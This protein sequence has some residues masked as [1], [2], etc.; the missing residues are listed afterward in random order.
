MGRIA[1]HS[2]A[3]AM[4]LTTNL[5]ESPSDTRGL[6]RS[7]CTTVHTKYKY[8]PGDC[9]GPLHCHRDR[10]GE[11]E[12]QGEGDEQKEVSRTPCAE[13]SQ[14]R[15]PPVHHQADMLSHL[16]NM[17][18][19]SITCPQCATFGN[20]GLGDGAAL[21]KENLRQGC[22]EMV[23]FE[24]ASSGDSYEMREGRC[25]GRRAGRCLEKSPHRPSEL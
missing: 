3:I 20:C 9:Q 19:S 6:S 14:A 8:I 11:R 22:H 24:F 5:S 2:K 16:H 1:M 21:G 23:E 15:I 13:H 4:Q 17:L 7:T 25:G 18:D 12:E 10:H